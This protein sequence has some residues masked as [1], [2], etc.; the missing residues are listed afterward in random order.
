MHEGIFTPALIGRII[1]I[2]IDN[3][4]SCQPSTIQELSILILLLLRSVN[5]ARARISWV[6]VHQ[7]DFSHEGGSCLADEKALK[8]KN[9][10]PSEGD[11]FLSWVSR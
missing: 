3:Q 2:S 4:Q 8:T 1:I 6:D 5:D 9:S 10:I 7:G 11:I